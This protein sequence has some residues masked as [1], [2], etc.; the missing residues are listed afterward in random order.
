VLGRPL[1]EAVELRDELHRGGAR[2]LQVARH[3]RLREVE[4]AA[5]ALERA[6]CAVVAMACAGSTPSVVRRGAYF[7]S[8]STVSGSVMSWSMSPRTRSSPATR[9]SRP[10]RKSKSAG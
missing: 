7:V 4:A 5:R 3:Q 8:A 9:G 6:I 10:E 1:Q 2:A